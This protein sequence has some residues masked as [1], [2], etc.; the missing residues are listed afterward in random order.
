MSSVPGR[1]DGDGPP[2]PGSP[3]DPRA[4]QPLKRPPLP[5]GNLP[6]S[7]APTVVVSRSIEVGATVPAPPPA[8]AR[9]PSVVPPPP[10]PPSQFPAPA[11]QRAPTGG[12]RPKAPGLDA[13][14]PEATESLWDSV[15]AL[16]DDVDAGFD[17]VLGE[18]GPRTQRDG[19]ATA[20]TANAAPPVKRSDSGGL[21][22]AREL[23][24]QLAAAHVRH[25]RDFMIDVKAGAATT[26]WLQLCVPAV[27]GVK[28]MATQLELGELA[29]S[30]DAY[31]EALKSAAAESGFSVDGPARERLLATYAPL[32]AA[33][34]QA[35]GLDAVKSRREG[36]IVQSLLLQI[37]GVR[38]VSIDKLYA[39]GLTT[40]DAFYLAKPEEIAQTT[41]IDPE[42]AR[43]ISE[44]FKKYK[45]DVQSAV[46]DESRSAEHKRLEELA[47]MLADQ[48]GQF[49]RAERDDDSSR[50]REMR[51]ARDTTFL[52][53]KVL[54][55]RVGEVERLGKIDKLP[56]GQKVAEL[57]KYLDEA[58]NR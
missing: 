51:K 42:V 19:G 53:V 4:T 28:R 54:M 55:A 12:L 39:A 6:I 48:Q 45:K 14:S 47:K 49:E 21:S 33:V 23:F 13:N 50:K 1:K 17:A 52:E 11:P 56:F 15:E 25:V 3:S 9:P 24:M 26:E 31:L 38:K 10:R 34:P 35:F 7:P 30:L 44:R 18:G 40:L 37:E 29:T 8:N 22:S 16:L 41:G 2:P 27:D 43:R 36:I 57:T 20:P 58:K 46:P 5:Q 32:I